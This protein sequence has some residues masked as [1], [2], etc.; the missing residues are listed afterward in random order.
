MKHPNN[1]FFKISCFWSITW[2]FDKHNF[3]CVVQFIWL[4]Y[5]EAQ[6]FCDYWWAG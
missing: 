5:L 6:K 2:R 1:F 3:Y 4:Y